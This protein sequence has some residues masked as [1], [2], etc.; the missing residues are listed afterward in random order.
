[1]EAFYEYE[2]ESNLK[3]EIGSPCTIIDAHFHS[4]MEVFLVKKGKYVITKNGNTQT[5][6]DGEIAVFDSYDVHSYDQKLQE[7][8]QNMVLII[9][10]RY[11]ENFNAKRQNKHIKNYIIKDEKLL[12]ELY[13]FSL[14]WLKNRKEEHVLFAGVQMFLSLLYNSLEFEDLDFSEGQAI[15]K[16]L[17]YVHQNFRFGITAKDVCKNLGYSNAYV[18]RVF[19]KYLKQSMPEYVNDMR[20]DYVKKELEKDR[21]KKVGQII[22]EA[23][24]KSIQSYYRNKSRKQLAVK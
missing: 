12:N 20:L 23:G 24:F 14:D 11:L 4:N 10:H 16:I 3:F 7:Q 6:S 8:T 2:R 17:N 18:S 15:R 1:M 22:L 13:S 5:I 19:H 9:P 21:D